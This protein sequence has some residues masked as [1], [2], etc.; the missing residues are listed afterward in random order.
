[1]PCGL[2]CVGPH[3]GMKNKFCC[4]LVA[5]IKVGWVSMYAARPPDSSGSKDK[6][7]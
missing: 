6:C 1:M 2:S 3:P 5:R 7:R 4:L